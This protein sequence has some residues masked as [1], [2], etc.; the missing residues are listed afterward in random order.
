MAPP[1]PPGRGG[2]DPRTLGPA[3]L[4]SDDTLAALRRLWGDHAVHSFPLEALR[5]DRARVADTLRAW[6]S[7]P[8]T[9]TLLDAVFEHRSNPSP[10]AAG[11]A[12]LRRLNRVWPRVGPYQLRWVEKRI[13][14][15]HAADRL[16]GHRPAVPPA[17]LD[18]C[19]F[20]EPP[21]QAEPG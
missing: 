14:L 2:R 19:K 13:P 21:H 8:D 1:T 3:Y 10:G 15:A 20:N 7:L 4:N 6:A 12:L 18:R 5:D 11:L 16:R 9:W 17:L